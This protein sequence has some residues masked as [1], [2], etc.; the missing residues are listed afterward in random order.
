MISIA[1]HFCD[2]H[3][4][5][6]AAGTKEKADV[7]VESAAAAGIDCLIQPGVRIGDWDAMVSLAQRHP[8]VYAAPGIHPMCADQWD[9]EAARQLKELTCHPKV[10][11]IGE[12]GLDA[13]VGPAQEV[14]ERA[15]RAQLQ[16]ALDHD[17]P[18]LLHCRQKKGALLAILRELDIGRHIGG[19]W[20]GF[21]G[22]LPFARELVDLG[23]VIGVGPVLLRHNARKLIEV[24]AALPTSSFVVET[25]LPDMARTPE[26]L[27]NVAKKIAEI[28]S[29]SLYGV[30]RVTTENTLK[31][32]SVP[33]RMPAPGRRTAVE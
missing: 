1:M 6:V 29:L 28:K 32:V 10:V 30:A 5:L 23:F 12:I 21:S 2:T 19:V 26:E 15:L 27:I 11:A 22:S 25:D 9:D 20:H 8:S 24:V 3:I 7:W 13:V 33:H 4:H 17:L 31:L 14:Q 18:V 16:I